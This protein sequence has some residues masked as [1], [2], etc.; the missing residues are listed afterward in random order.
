MSEGR[1]GR[2]G[3]SSSWNSGSDVDNDAM[4]D[5]PRERL[6]PGLS[7]SRV[8]NGL[9]HV[10]DR[11]RSERP[12]D[13][14]EAARAMSPYVEAG[15]TTFDMADHD[16]S[17]EDIAGIFGSRAERLTKWTPKPGPVSRESARAAV[18]RSL[19]RLRTDAIDLL[20]FRTFAFAD[21]SWLDAL[22][23]LQDLKREGLIRHIGV[24]NFDTAHLRIAVRSGFEIVSNQ[25]AFSLLDSRPSGAMADFCSLNGIHLLACGSLLGGF[26]SGRWLGKPEPDWNGLPTA[27]LV[28][29]GRTIRAAGGWDA[30][31]QLLRRVDDVATKHDVPISAVAIRAI[32][33]EAAVGAV[34]VGARLK[35][36]EH[37]EDTLQVLS[38]SL[39]DADWLTLA[40][41]RKYIK[42]LSG[43]CGDGY[44]PLHHVEA[45]PPPYP[46]KPGPRGR[47]IV[48]S[49]TPWEPLAG[50]SRAHRLD[51]RIW[52]SG[53]TAMHGGRAV[54]GTDAVAQ[55]HAIIDKI[56]GA[57]ISLGAGLSDVVRTRVYVR[58]LADGEAIARAHGER[59]RSIM[60]ATTQ[61]QAGLVG[62]E[63]L[64][65]V[66]VE[67][68]AS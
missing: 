44:D 34:I 57:L 26:L 47:T 50:A 23:H 59:F 56:E 58:N 60:P 17:A 54:G 42:P 20:Q 67:A 12:L 65:E 19:R 49:G 52:V 30:F 28:K 32:L 41:G 24:A 68:V 45:A 22:S 43:D 62:E 29:H 10:A 4:T 25:V 55:F 35:Q 15:L 53:T 31:Q 36:S 13:L 8:I 40:R 64:V 1:P 3:I 38:L 39:D 2:S 16:G 27:S 6:A 37:I 51:D 9:F 7:V 14:E 61:V 18:E 48:L 5:V 63:H 46:V 33:D 21:P 66:E 11:Q